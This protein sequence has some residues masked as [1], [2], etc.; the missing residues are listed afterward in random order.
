MD[1]DVNTVRILE[2]DGG[3][4]RG[5]TSLTFLKEFCKLVGVSEREFLDSF[6]IIVGA[7]IGGIQ[8]CAY[9]Y[10]LTPTD[11][12]GFFINDSKNI[13][14]IRDWGDYLTWSD[15]TQST[16]N[17]PN[18]LQMIKFMLN[19]DPF[20]KS[21]SE[22]SNY[23][24]A[25]LRSKLQE[26]FGNATLGDLKKKVLI[27]SYEYPTQ[28]PVIFSNYIADEYIGHPKIVDNLDGTTSTE[29]VY[30]SIVNI[31]MA[32][33]AAPVYF[34]EAKFNDK[35]Y[36][37]GG[38]YCNNLSSVALGLGKQIKPFAK[39]TCMLSV[40]TGLNKIGFYAKKQN[41]STF[42]KIKDNFFNSIFKFSPVNWN[43][44]AKSLTKLKDLIEIGMTASQEAVAFG[45]GN[46]SKYG[47]NFNNTL[48]YYRYQTLLDKHKDWDLDN[49]NSEFL[50]ELKSVAKN[51][52]QADK[53]ELKLFYDKYIL[54]YKSLQS[55]GN[56][57]PSE[58]TE[59]T[60]PPEPTDT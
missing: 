13:F 38:V 21:A 36:I 11:I 26:V 37:D 53:L 25:R 60:K 2:L 24:H 4:T 41:Q 28:T 19:N 27:S 31:C 9:A 35:T 16:S 12:E 15:D 7:S 43:D 34:P 20:Y 48:H 8:A 52:V 32:T 33:S 42:D 50:A 59:P 54:G 18:A 55:S 29:G 56:E 17:R 57:D 22:T 51:K 49:T 23:G 10:G 3:G 6:D 39:R 58:P 5:Y 47:V 40:G 45:I 44:T 46:V 30:E 14:T 1:L